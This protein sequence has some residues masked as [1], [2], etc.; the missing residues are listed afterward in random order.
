MWEEFGV[1]IWSDTPYWLK[2]FLEY[3]LTKLYDYL[4]R[5]NIKHIYLGH[6]N[7]KE[8]EKIIFTVNMT[9]DYFK[10]EDKLPKFYFT[11]G[12]V[13]VYKKVL[14]ETFETKEK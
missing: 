1:G 7:K 11:D 2:K 8:I 10:Y 5:K 12:A 9:P 4:L 14:V 3:K 6:W 13:V